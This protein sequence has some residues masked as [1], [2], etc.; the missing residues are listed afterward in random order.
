MHF[1]LEID[2][3]IVDTSRGGDPIDYTAGE[4]PFQGLDDK[5]LGLKAGDKKE[6][7]VGPAEGYGVL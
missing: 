7:T 5:L 6:V 4:G 3:R 1:A 2:G